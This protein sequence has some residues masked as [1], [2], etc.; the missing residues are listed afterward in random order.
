MTNEA[1]RTA[2]E[3]A[4]EYLRAHR[5]EARYT[6]TPVTATLGAGL[7]VRTEDPDGLAVETDMPKAV[8]GAGERP[9]PGFLFRAAVAS[10]VASLIGMRAAQ[11]G[12]ELGEVEVTVDSGSDDYGILGLDDTV[13]AGPLSKRIR[14]RVAHRGGADSIDEARAREL[15]EWAVRHCPSSESLSR[16]VPVDLRATSAEP[17]ATWIWGTCSSY[18]ITSTGSRT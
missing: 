10:C 14:V 16:V 15:A 2:I 9:S 17:Q 12:I 8:G 3:R 13:P 7:R 6:D 1:V 5:D 11:L 4:S 18:R